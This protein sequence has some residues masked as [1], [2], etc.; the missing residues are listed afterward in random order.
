MGG[1]HEDYG[2]KETPSSSS[3]LRRSDGRVRKEW[4]SNKLCLTPAVRK[5]EEEN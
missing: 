2:S 3:L 5:E 1:T 4:V